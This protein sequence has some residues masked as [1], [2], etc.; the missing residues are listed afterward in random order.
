M[1]KVISL[2]D[3][4]MAARNSVIK[5]MQQ[6]ADFND[7]LLKDYFDQESGAARTISIKTPEQQSEQSY[8][9]SLDVPLLAIAP[10]SRLGLSFVGIALA[11]WVMK[12]DGVIHVFIPSETDQ[13][14]N[15]SFTK[16][17]F[18]VTVNPYQTEDEF[19]KELGSI[20][21]GV[22]NQIII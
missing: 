13:D 19:I 5:S 8:A 17:N 7:E 14:T 6:I 1:G 11:L 15:T 18:S 22:G 16:V 10:L 9:A 4:L 2:H 21:A 3:F 20:E 12:I